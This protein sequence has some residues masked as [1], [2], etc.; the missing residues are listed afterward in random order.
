MSCTTYK[1]S[2]VIVRLRS[3]AIRHANHSFPNPH[4]HVPIV[5]ELK[6]LSGDTASTA[7][8]YTNIYQQSSSLVRNAIL[9][10]SAALCAGFALAGLTVLIYVVATTNFSPRQLSQTFQLPLD[11]S[12]NELTSQI[13]LQ[14]HVT[15]GNSFKNTVPSP[16]PKFLS[17]GQR[18][19]AWLE[20]KIPDLFLQNDKE[21][22]FVHIVGEFL[23]SDGSVTAKATQPFLLRSRRSLV[24]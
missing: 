14:S 8:T 10:L 17:P 20:L 9:L 6:A 16:N 11:I 1:S 13:A 2:K 24:W 5:Q 15:D 7:P 18:F 4:T 23:A 19:D 22:D 12:G 3:T 21:K